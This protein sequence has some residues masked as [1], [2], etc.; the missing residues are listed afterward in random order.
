[1]AKKSG[2]RVKKGSRAGPLSSKKAKL[3]LSDGQAWGHPLTVQQRRFFAWVA[4]GKKKG[5]RRKSGKRK[6]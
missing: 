5:K 3:I 1:M 4:G 2:R 6:R